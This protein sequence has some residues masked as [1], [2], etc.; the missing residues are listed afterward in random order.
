MRAC[1]A[2]LKIVEIWSNFA[3]KK[4]VILSNF[5]TFPNF[6][7]CKA[8]EDF[9]ISFL[10]IVHLKGCLG[11]IRTDLKFSIFFDIWLLKG[12]FFLLVSYG[13][14]KSMLYHALLF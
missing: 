5:R 1:T 12:Y 9:L 8:L 6:S 10:E 4:S 2:S 13:V 11:S 3:N 7:K 14:R